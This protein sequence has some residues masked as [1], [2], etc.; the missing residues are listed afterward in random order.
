MTIKNKLVNS[1]TASALIATLFAGTALAEA[2][3]KS[4]AST[5]LPPASSTA[6][7]KEEKKKELPNVTILAT[8][9]TIAGSA[10]SNTSTTGYKAGALGVD[11]L[12]SAVPE[13]AEIANVSGEQIANT[14]SP[15]VNNETLIKLANRINELLKTDEVD[16]VVVTHGTDTLEETA[17]FL[18]LTVKSDKP[19]VVVGAMR[20][21]TAISADGPMNLYN[22]VLL[23]GTE[24]A[25]G[26]GVMI[27]LN[28][29]IGSARHTTKT[30]TTALDTF[31]ATEQG[32][33]GMIA[34]GVPYFYS[35][36]TAKHT[37]ESVFDVSGLTELP[38]VDIIYSYQN[39]GRYLY[40]A[41]VEAGA[42]GIVTAGSGNGS[43]SSIGSEALEDAA[44][45]GVVVVRSSRV[46]SGIVT[47]RGQIT[48]MSLNP[49]KA[50]ILLMLALT[51]TTDADKIKEYFAEY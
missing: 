30:N 6:A 33:I 29:R 18:N 43:L 25:K 5:A 14:G 21:A 39:E 10:A 12:I 31:K 42:K 11:I 7:A 27:M 24:E 19:V 20:P 23:A 44:E 15:N 46:G 8:G 17:Y 26:R 1:I 49:Q 2:P 4:T 13:M 22:S 9:G 47:P 38:Q 16:G 32:Y 3:L 34:G 36:I 51:K 35:E 40:D 37:T 41:A 48:S 50:R 45:K 28:D